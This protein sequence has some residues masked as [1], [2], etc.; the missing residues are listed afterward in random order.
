MRKITL[1]TIVLAIGALLCPAFVAGCRKDASGHRVDTAQ[2][3]SEERAALLPAEVRVA[4]GRDYPGAK[5]K[6]IE[7]HH[8]DGATHWK[9]TFTTAEGQTLTRDYDETGGAVKH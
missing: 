4:I 9:V 8:E 7:R 3:T 1:P 5:I 6:K 2:M